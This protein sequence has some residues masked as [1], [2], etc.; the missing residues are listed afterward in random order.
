MAHACWRARRRPRP[1]EEQRAAAHRL[2]VVGGH[3][4]SRAARRASA[5]IASSATSPTGHQPLAIALADHPDERAVE[6]DVLEVEVQRLGD[7]QARGVQELQERP[8]EEASSAG[9]G[10][11]PLDLGLGEGLRQEAGHPRQVE[12]RRRRRCR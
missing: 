2:D 4:R 6:R 10:E 1:P 11:Q 3:E 12:V 8:V 7:A 5:R 9:G